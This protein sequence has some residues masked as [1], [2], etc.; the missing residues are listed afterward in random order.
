MVVLQQTAEA[1]PALDVAIDSAAFVNRFEE[2]V[3]EALVVSAP[4]VTV[5]IRENTRQ[6]STR[7]V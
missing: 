7:T 1:L 6:G 5:E 2:T 4:T 3:F